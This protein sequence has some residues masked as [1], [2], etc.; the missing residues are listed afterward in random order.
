MAEISKAIKKVAELQ[1]FLEDLNIK[2][3]YKKR[4]IEE[5]QLFI[6]QKTMRILVMKEQEA[7][8]ITRNQNLLRL[9]DVLEKRRKSA[10]LK[11][12]QLDQVNSQLEALNIED[13]I[14]REN[15]ENRMKETE[16]KIKELSNSK[17]ARIAASVEAYRQ[18]AQEELFHEQAKRDMCVKKLE[19]VRLVAGEARETKRLRVDAAKKKNEEELVKLKASNQKK[20]A[21]SR[22][23]LKAL[24]DKFEKEALDLK[25]SK[26][27]LIKQLRDRLETK[28]TERERLETAADLQ[29]KQEMPSMEAR[30]AVG[31]G[32]TGYRRGRI[33]ISRGFRDLMVSPRSDTVMDSPINPGHHERIRSR[34][35]LVTSAAGRARQGSHTGHSRQSNISAIRGIHVYSGDDEVDHDMVLNSRLEGRSRDVFL[36]NND[37]QEFLRLQKRGSND[38]GKL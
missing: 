35:P 9:K 6:Q 29:L 38:V 37:Y 11:K 20:V 15:H 3:Q 21:A 31:G 5:T 26:V 16:E 30:G 7:A 36:Q 33:Q 17:E 32:D 24:D 28:R 14:D 34:S 18:S 1:E 25:N 22:Q 27:H 2:I 4:K 23:K 8:L 13:Q 19:E 12:Q 10:Q